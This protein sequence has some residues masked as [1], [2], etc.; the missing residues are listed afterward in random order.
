M[1]E[2]EN[3][4]DPGFGADTSL[5]PETEEV[6]AD[7][8]APEVKE[9]ESEAGSPPAAEEDSENKTDPFQ[10]R[11]DKLTESFRESER[12]ADDL[13]VANDR[14]KQELADRPKPVEPRKTLADF[15]HDTEAYADYRF[16]LADKNAEVAADKR[17]ARHQGEQKA[18]VVQS[19][20]ANREKVFAKTVDDYQSVAYADDLK[21]SPT[22]AQEIRESEIG[23]EVVYH[24]GKNPDIASEISRMPPNAAIREMTLLGGRLQV[25]M[26][27]K[28]DTV[29]KAPPPPA[30]IKG[31]AASLSVST[32]DSKSDKMSDADWFNAEEKRQAKL[33]G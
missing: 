21:I 10:K 26:S 12:S 4:V 1:S 7:A 31:S 15:D 24:L 6:K 25:E 8:E 13:R 19:E 28:G 2:S 32:T 5:V 17:F 16:D 30:K 18:D 11:I 23:P 3:Q 9:P 33:R 14:L 20:H 22:M 27:K 29:S